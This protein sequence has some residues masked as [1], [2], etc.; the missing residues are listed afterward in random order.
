[1]GDHKVDEKQKEKLEYWFYQV[2]DLDS[3]LYALGQMFESLDPQQCK[4]RFDA[5]FF[6]GIGKILCDISELLEGVHADI[7]DVLQDGWEEEPNQVIN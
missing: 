2:S 1:M 6:S 3:R 7:R 5:G 4:E